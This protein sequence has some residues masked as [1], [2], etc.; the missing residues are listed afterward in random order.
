[1][2]WAPFGN[3]DDGSFEVVVIRRTGKIRMIL[4]SRKIY[5]GHL[6]GMDGVSQ[7]ESKEV[8]VEPLDPISIELDGE[9]PPIEHP[10]SIR[11]RNIHAQLPVV[12]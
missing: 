6:E 5:G 11:F 10:K 9:I 2:K 3:L 12:L 8:L 7:Y 4:D 1:M